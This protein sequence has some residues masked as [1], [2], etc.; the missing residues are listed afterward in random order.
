[1]RRELRRAFSTRISTPLTDW[2][3]AP[4]LPIHELSAYNN[5]AR[6]AALFNRVERR[7][8]MDGRKEKGDYLVAPMQHLFEFPTQ[9]LTSQLRKD[10]FPSTYSP[11]V[12]YT[13]L[14]YAGGEVEWHRPGYLEQ[15]IGRRSMMEKPV[16]K[17]GK[18]G[19]LL[20]VTIHHL[21]Y[22]LS[23]SYSLYNAAEDNEEGEEERDLFKG[24]EENVLLLSERRRY[25]YRSPD[26]STPQPL[27]RS[28]SPL[29][30]SSS[31]K[32][33][34]R[35]PALSSTLLFRFSAL[36]YNA[37]RIH[38]D[39]IYAA[40]E[41]LSAPLVHG[42][43]Q[44][45]LIAD[46]ASM[47]ES[48]R[49]VRYGAPMLLHDAEIVKFDSSSSSFTPLS[50]LSLL[51]RYARLLNFSYK[52]LQPLIVDTEVRVCMSALD[53]KAGKWIAWI[54]HATLPNVRYMEAT[55][56]YRPLSDDDED[57]EKKE[58]DDGWSWIDVPLYSLD[59]IASAP[60]SVHES[61]SVV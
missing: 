23:S 4:R 47:L 34:L 42:P 58:E 25:V 15:R 21:Y 18:N 31:Y 22:S 60:C 37:H 43:L 38:Y 44:A 9:S 26:S 52:A 41:G 8:K 33:I 29:S 39:P 40:S 53:E 24:D 36:T 35:T 32:L 46:M 1:M 7:V 19:S 11:P 56:H 20:F 59:F 6:Y 28:L 17:A 2:L 13:N 54:E 48:E 3:H 45:M 51:P 30:S 57:G 14:L 61:T 12:P 50:S 49:V 10:G 5:A 55:I 16:L 27:N